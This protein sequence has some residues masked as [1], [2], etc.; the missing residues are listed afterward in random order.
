[1]LYHAIVIPGRRQRVRPPI[2]GLPEI[3]N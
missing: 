2:S 1:M 3:G